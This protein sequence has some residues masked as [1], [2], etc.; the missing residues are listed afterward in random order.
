MVATVFPTRL[1]AIAT[2]RP[3]PSPAPPSVVHRSPP[4]FDAARL[5][6]IE[7]PTV[8]VSTSVRRSTLLLLIGLLAGVVLVG[9]PS[10]AAA[11]SSDEVDYLNRINAVRAGVGVGPL[12]FD[13]NM[14]DLARQHNDVMASTENLFHTPVLT[15]GV[16]VD[17]LKLGENVG[18]GSN[19]TVVFDAFVKSSHHYDNIVDPS[20]THIGIAV[21][22]VGRIQWT[23]HRFVQI[24]NVAPKPVFVPPPPPPSTFPPTTRPPA[25]PPPTAP[26]VT[27][28]P[29]TLPPVTTPPTTTGPTVPTVPPTTPTPVAEPAPADARQVDELLRVLR[30]SG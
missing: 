25:P 14:N 9:S 22:V 24:N 15:A 16:N 7:G 4:A 11:A 18:M 20:F 3:P 2:P 13:G 21:T 23:T 27:R 30:V 28:P 12:S 29:V 26:P 6:P 19:T 1:T 10:A 8:S 5:H 17:W